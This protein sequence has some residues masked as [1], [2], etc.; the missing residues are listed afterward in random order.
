MTAPT[1]ISEPADLSR[2]QT[3][4]FLPGRSLHL[5]LQ[6]LDPNEARTWET[7]LNRHYGTCGCGTSAA[8]LSVALCGSVFVL[9]TQPRGLLA[10][11]AGDLGLAAIVVLSAGIVGKLVGM[12]MARVRL[13]L[14]IRALRRRLQP[15]STGSA[16]QLAGSGPVMGRTAR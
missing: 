3:S 15:A 14:T 6:G 11:G 9:A 13:H 7:R 16:D 4:T 2:V 12:A 10:A 1:V 8:F 5:R